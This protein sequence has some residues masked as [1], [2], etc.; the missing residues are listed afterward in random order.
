MI[1]FRFLTQYYEKVTAIFQNYWLKTF[2]T[3]FNES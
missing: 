2:Q 3:M 1:L